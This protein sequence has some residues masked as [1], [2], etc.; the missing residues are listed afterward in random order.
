LTYE[1]GKKRN[2]EFMNDN[3]IKCYCGHTTYCDCVP[4]TDHLPNVGKMVEHKDF[5]Q[6]CNCKERMGET[7]CCNQCGMPCK[8]SETLYTEEQVKQIVQ[9]S[10]ETGLTAEYIMLSLKQP[11]K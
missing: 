5:S 3:L 9:K 10:R 7:W 11:K 1:R 2:R 8:M 6:E 4:P